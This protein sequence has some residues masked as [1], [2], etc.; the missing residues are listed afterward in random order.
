MLILHPISNEFSAVLTKTSFGKDNG[1]KCLF[2]LTLF[3]VLVKNKFVN[4]CRVSGILRT[5]YEIFFAQTLIE[6]IHLCY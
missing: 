1:R 6:S 4:L 2:L 3:M 5:K